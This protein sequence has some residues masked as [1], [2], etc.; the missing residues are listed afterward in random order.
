MSSKRGRRKV[1]VTQAN[2]ITGYIN[3]S[4]TIS[5]TVALQIV[6]ELVCICVR[7][8]VYIAK[9]VVNELVD[10][11]EFESGIHSGANVNKKLLNHGSPSI[12]GLL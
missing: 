1:S 2:K 3:V 6:N 4:R 8:A 9:A 10:R 7:P 11:I 5:Q 12:R